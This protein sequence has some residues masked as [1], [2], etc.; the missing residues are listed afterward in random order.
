MFAARKIAV[1]GGG[2]FGV[3]IAVFLSRKG[4]KV[5][6][7]EQ[8][9]DIL[10]AASGIN[11]FRLHRGHHY[12]RSD[13]TIQDC[14]RGEMLFR[15]EYGAAVIDSGQQHYLIPKKGSFTTPEDFIKI[16]DQYKL[17]YALARPPKLVRT[18]P[19]ALNIKV[20]EGRIDPV[21]LKKI[22]LANI[23]KFGVNLSLNDRVDK[24]VWKA[25]DDVVVA[26][27]ASLNELIPNKHKRNYQF[28]VCEKPVVRLPKSFNG[29]SLIFVDGPFFCIDPLG[30]SDLF[31]MGNVN[32]A[33]HK[34]SVGQMP[35][36]PEEIK[37]LLNRGIIRKPSISNFKLF[38]EAGIPFVPALVRAEHVGSMFTV[39]T[40]L[41]NREDT[42]ER[43]TLVERVGKKT[44][45]VFSG[46]IGNCVEAAHSVYSLLDRG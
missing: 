27:Y 19:I 22:C 30:R 9:K 20:K 3:T 15:S 6:L 38:I 31:I 37:P 25:Y 14:L 12:P 11:Q 23:K 4:I 17:E 21:I 44:I 24:K 29:R 10:Q 26:T 7:Y 34:R 5:D 2:I 41:P 42:D 43:P 36:V 33:I 13:R 39:R 16:S 8:N 45:V 1:I 32:H 18:E 28:E 40:V 35:E 46:K